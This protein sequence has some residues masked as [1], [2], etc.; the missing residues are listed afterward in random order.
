MFTDC[1]PTVVHNLLFCLTLET[2]SSIFYSPALL[3]FL[4][5]AAALFSNAYRFSSFLSIDQDFLSKYPFENYK[6][7][8]QTLSI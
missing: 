6:I 2:D 5:M 4:I 8:G 3:I 7:A 1:K